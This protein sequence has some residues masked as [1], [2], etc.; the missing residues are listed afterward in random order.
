MACSIIYFTL[1]YF[2]VTLVT[3]NYY[4]TTG[5]V[6]QEKRKSLKDE[7]EQGETE[8]KCQ[9]FLDIL[10]SAQVNLSNF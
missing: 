1:I 5:Q 4:S 10:L 8:K 9:D 6:I 3:G 2:V 7:K